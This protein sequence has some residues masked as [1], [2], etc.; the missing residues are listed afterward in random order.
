MGTGKKVSA[1]YL[2]VAPL[3]FPPNCSL[4]NILIGGSGKV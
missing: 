2:G 4:L 1:Y 3:L